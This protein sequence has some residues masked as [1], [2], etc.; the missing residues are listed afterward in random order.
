MSLKA[1]MTTTVQP[2]NG[3]CLEELQTERSKAIQLQTEVQRLKD[4]LLKTTEKVWK[5]RHCT[6]ICFECN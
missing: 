2:N 3:K 6:S 1:A 5:A 4:E